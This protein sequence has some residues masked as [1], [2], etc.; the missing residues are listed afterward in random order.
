MSLGTSYATLAELRD[1][2][3]IT[4]AGDTA[5]DTKLTNALA[6][7][8][9]GIEKITGR[10]F[11]DAGSASARVFV[12]DGPTCTDID[13]F[14]TTVGLVVEADQ[15]DDGTYETTWTSGAYQLEPLNGVVGGESGW[16]FW[17]IRAVG[18]GWFP[19]FSSGRASLRV[20]ARWGWAAVP[21]AVHE[22]CLIVAEEI[23]RLKDA[24]FGVAGSSEFGVIRV[25]DNQVAASMIAP[26]RRYPLLVA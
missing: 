12:P 22:A 10:Q 17:T 2:I 8:S 19:M 26:Y 15:G 9:R 25:R 6:A 14:S 23:Y 4:A 1:R 16:P 20:T 11:N 13:D 21:A 7:A 5:E 18:S 24:P 3:G